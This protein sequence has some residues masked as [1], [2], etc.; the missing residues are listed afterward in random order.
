MHPNSD[1]WNCQRGC[2]YYTLC[3]CT[4]LFVA[5]ICCRFWYKLQCQW[6]RSWLRTPLAPVTRTQSKVQ[7]T[8]QDRPPQCLW[9]TSQKR[10]LTCWCGSCWRWV[11]G[12]YST[13]F[14]CAVILN[15]RHITCIELVL[16]R[17]KILSSFTDSLCYRAHQICKRKFKLTYLTHENQWGLLLIDVLYVCALT[18]NI[19]IFVS[20]IN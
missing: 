18:K 16:S 15:L 13:S 17:N 9:E 14:I 20:K 12:S 8:T 19:L 2:V 4:L 3:S 11:F 7:V 5:E 6:F 1:A 10:P